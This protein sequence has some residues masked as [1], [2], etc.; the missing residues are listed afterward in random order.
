MTSLPSSPGSGSP[1]AA[2]GYLS[3]ATAVTGCFAGLTGSFQIAPLLVLT[4]GLALFVGG[5]ALRRRGVRVSGRILAGIGLAVVVTACVGAFVLAP[6]PLGLVP[7][8]LCS[9]G[10][11]SVAFALFPT[12]VRWLRGL[13]LTG[14]TLV[15]LGIVANTVI[16]N[17]PLWRS[18]CAVSLLLVA[19][20]TAER[21]ISLGEQID[22]HTETAELE[23]A[24]A[25][26]TG[27]VAG[28]AV[29]LT[30]AVASLPAR[31]SSVLGIGLLLTAVAVFGLT[32]FRFPSER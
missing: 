30:L 15:F 6:S 31:T 17:P 26:T 14:M 29:F 10:L 2:S 21:G 9:V 25:A 27:L 24:N 11:V 19:W 4:A 7:I 1:T 16:A 32:F 13:M 22:N 8:L 23:F 3:L 12:Y 18:I 5:T 28:F 20:D